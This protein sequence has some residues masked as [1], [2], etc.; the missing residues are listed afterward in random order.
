MSNEAGPSNGAHLRRTLTLWDLILYGVIVLQ[1]VAPMSAFGALS[2]RGRGHVVTAVLI[3]MVAMMATAVGYGKMASVYPSAG[4]AFTYVAREIHPAA[5]Y[6]TGW[7]MVMDYI[8]NPLIC[9]IWCAGQAH[10]FAPG[11]PIWAWKIVFAVVF[12]LLNLQ[13][14][15]TSARLNAGLAAAMGV[16][17]ILVFVKT[18]AYIFG[19]PH[20]EPGFFTRPF[21]DPKTFTV[22]NLFGCTSLAVLT[23]IGFDGISTLSEETENPRR[24]IMLATVMTCLAVGILSASEVYVAQL[25]WPA[26]QPFPNQD[27]A[28]VYAAARAWA[29]L[30]TIVGATLLVANFGS[31]MGAQIGAARLLYG[32]GKSNALPKSFFGKVDARHGI[33]QNNVLFIGVIV[34][35]GAYFLTFEQGIG[36]L[37]YGAL[38]AFMGVNASSFVHYFVKKRV[39]TLWNFIVPFIGFFVCLG[40]WWNLSVR[41]KI[42]GSAWMAAGIAFGAWKTK[43]FR[44]PLSFDAPAE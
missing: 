31:G 19:H 3:A 24:N 9:T 38:L 11:L 34:L 15:K 21:Y 5:G 6:I 42:L 7:S 44:E 27:T 26:S 16:V 40:L 2:D 37:N 22:D 36:L 12:T 28:Y 14:I 35:I 10:E 30:F 20:S 39:R 4:S 29:P 41:A 18:I 43:G 17:V 1:P 23:Y 33:P 8:V 32:M 25:V 13:G